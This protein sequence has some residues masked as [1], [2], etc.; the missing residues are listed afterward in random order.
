MIDGEPQTFR[1]TRRTAWALLLL[2]CLGPVLAVFLPVLLSPGESLAQLGEVLTSVR[3]GVLLTKTCGMAAATAL[4]AC[5]VGLPF[6]C[7]L[8]ERR[9]P[10]RNGVACLLIAPL[11]VPQHVLA[12]AWI[13]VLGQQGL[14]ARW[15]LPHLSPYGPLGVVFVQALAWYPI[16]LIAVWYRL[17]H[18]DPG[19]R[20]A[21]RTLADGRTRFLRVTLP[22]L[23]PALR[24]S[25]VILFVLSLLSFSVPS[26]L[27]VDGFTVEIFTSFNSL[28]DQRQAVLVALP[29]VL[30]GVVAM[31]WMTRKYSRSPLPRAA[32]SSPGQSMGWSRWMA[33]G[34]FVGATVAL[35]I[36]AMLARVGGA[37]ALL[38]AWHTGASE[39]GTTAL[40]GVVGA[41]ATLLLVL[42][43]TMGAGRMARWAGWIA[44][45]AYLVSGPVFGAGLIQLWNHAGVP[46]FLYDRFPILLIAVVGRYALF[47][48]LGCALARQWLP[49]ATIDAARNLGASPRELLLRVALPQIVRPLLAT[50]ACLFVLIAGELEC[51]ILVAPPGWV[52]VS[53]RMYTLMHYGPD[54]MVSALA[55]VQAATAATILACLAVTYFAHGVYTP[56]ESRYHT[57]R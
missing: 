50:W 29:L 28:L 25:A 23:M 24:T 43:L 21:A 46:G 41:S 55:L 44:A 51:I 36:A 26:L 3:R 52:P 32:V 14:L 20:D 53:L 42:P 39:I 10:W 40:L 57:S 27:Q 30:T 8:E 49:T 34:L 9:I 54:G 6:G 33:L 35:P 13:D 16:P 12:V 2:L 7:W 31:G 47:A 5:L 19:L 22:L 56:R 1:W 45:M 18:L 38:R 11:L 4:L 15:G 17:R 37:A 48:W